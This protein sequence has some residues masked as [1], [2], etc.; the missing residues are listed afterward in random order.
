[1]YAIRSYYGRSAWHRSRVSRRRQLR[2][3]E[4]L[5]RLAS[6]SRLRVVSRSSVLRYTD[7][8]R[9]SIR[10][11][12][13]ELGVEAVID[14][15]VRY[16]GDQIRVSATLIDVAEDTPIWPETYPGDLSNVENIFRI[17]ADIAMN[18]AR[19]NFV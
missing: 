4:V 9:P 16:A 2:A 11:I 10:Q 18:V 19:N 1:M 17:Q 5:N 7:Q 12:G 15:S 6:L 14:G 8:Q 13:E 3:E